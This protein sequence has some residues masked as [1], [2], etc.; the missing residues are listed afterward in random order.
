[1]K[2]LPQFYNGETESL[3]I[4]TPQTPVE[5]ASWACGLCS[6][7]GPHVQKSHTWFN[8]LPYCLEVLD[9]L[10]FD[11]VFYVKSDGRV[12]QRDT[13]ACPW[14]QQVH[15]DPLHAI[16]ESTIPATPSTYSFR[17]A[18]QHPTPESPVEKEL[19]KTHNESTVDISP[20]WLRGIQYLERSWVLLEPEF[21]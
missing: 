17:G 3:K 15:A 21:A 7:M 14:A 18:R 10:V 16:C 6:P 20:L 2:L 4:R 9:N 1:M 19:S 13:G 11:S 8:A 12:G 5:P